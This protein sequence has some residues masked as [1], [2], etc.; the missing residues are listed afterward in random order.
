MT[1]PAFVRS[2]LMAGAAAATATAVVLAPVRVLP[3]DI[4]VPAHATSTQPALP[5][6][7]VELLAAASR[8]TA[9][10]AP[11]VPLPTPNAGSGL[12]SNAGPAAAPSAAAIAPNLANTIDQAYITVEPWVRYGFELAAYAV[13]WIPYVGWLSGLIIDGY[14]FGQSIVASAVFN[15]TDW[16]RGDG[17]IVTNLVD[18]GVDVGLAF[19]WLG[20]D[21]AGTF[22]PLP[23]LPLPPRPPLQGPFLADMLAAPTAGLDSSA[24]D[25]SLPSGDLV[26]NTITDAISQAYTSL[27]NTGAFAVNDAANS[28]LNGVGL[29]FVTAPLDAAYNV[30]NR[31]AGPGVDFG[32]D[33]ISLPDQYLHDVLHDGQDPVTALGTEAGFIT[34]GAIDNG[35]AAV[36]NAISTITGIPFAGSTVTN[37]TTTPALDA[38]EAQA[39]NSTGTGAVE[40]VAEK[41]VKQLPGRTTTT[42]TELFTAV[43]KSV[44]QSL[45]PWKPATTGSG[46]ASPQ[47]L[48]K[49]VRDG[50]RNATAN[51]KSAIQ[52]ATD[53]LRSG[54]KNTD[55]TKPAD[56]AT[57]TT[58]DNPAKGKSGDE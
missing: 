5:K 56:T 42:R 47:S 58:A 55:G 40:N 21:V 9:V 34:R 27:T 45:Q 12:A 37:A 7:M 6:A 43:P 18:F 31:V 10:P 52:K 26:T 22:V 8:M 17:T 49:D 32:N 46:T 38:A 16:L 54:A 14:N 53:G 35:T 4:A 20:I 28:I 11:R 25:V 33:V 41:V 57:K 24:G 44:R 51:L 29:A 3:A 48:V 1:V 30:V 19:V 50:V 39:T 15:F 36:D 23:P 2:Y 13:G